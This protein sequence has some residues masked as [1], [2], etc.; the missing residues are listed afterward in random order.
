[1]KSASVQLPS[2]AFLS[3]VMF[4]P[5]KVPK[6]VFSARPPAKGTAPSLSSVW[7]PTQ[8]PA[9][10]RYSPCFASPCARALPASK[11]RSTSQRRIMVA[12]YALEKESPAVAGLFRASALL[13]LL[14]AEVL[15][16]A[17]AGLADAAD[18]GLLR[19]LVAAPGHGYERRDGL[20]EVVLGLLELGRLAPDRGEGGGLHRRVLARRREPVPR[21]AG[22]RVEQR[23]VHRHGVVV[24]GDLALGHA[25]ERAEVLALQGHGSLALLDHDLGFDLRQRCLGD[26]RAQRERQTGEQ[27]P[28]VHSILLV[29]C[30]GRYAKAL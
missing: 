13:L 11:E 23:G 4:G 5:K 27:K 18:R 30:F 16:A 21:H 10:T 12:D 17:A 3:G 19:G 7:Q 24:E 2:P 14:L 8:P 29:S 6:G 22:E 26:A 15:V 20:V 28:L 9:F 25:G 1:M